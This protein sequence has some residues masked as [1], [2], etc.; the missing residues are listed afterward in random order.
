MDYFLE[1]KVKHNVKDLRSMGLPITISVHFLHIQKR[2]TN[3]YYVSMCYTQNIVQ[4]LGEKNV[5][6]ECKDNME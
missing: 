1:R 6:K 3:I 5:S 4:K 2:N